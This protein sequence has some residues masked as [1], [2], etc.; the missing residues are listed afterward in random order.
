MASL[1]ASSTGRGAP[2]PGIGAAPGTVEPVD[3]GVR[4][5]RV[6]DGSTRASACARTRRSPCAESPTSRG[7]GP[8]VIEGGT[9]KRS[10]GRRRGSG[11]GARRSIRRPRVRQS[12]SLS[13][14]PAGSSTLRSP[15]SGLLSCRVAGPSATANRHSVGDRG[16][17][18]VST[19]S[20]RGR[21]GADPDPAGDR[22][23]GRL[24]STFR[25][26]GELRSAPRAG[27]RPPAAAVGGRSVRR[28]SRWA[29]ARRSGS[30]GAGPASDRTPRRSSGG[31]W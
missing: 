19:A 22:E 18:L 31:A 29:A 4:R 9:G 7:C 1:M 11:G 23:S 2:D 6:H 13:R 3:R 30:S 14:V 21:R 27:S 26:P 5:G 12:E 8:V 10:R 25:P 17:Q 15:L 28:A 20:R 16:S 24:P